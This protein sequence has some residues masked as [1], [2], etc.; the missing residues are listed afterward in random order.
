MGFAR[1]R[2]EHMRFVV[3]IGLGGP[4]DEDNI[5]ISS[6]YFGCE[7]GPLSLEMPIC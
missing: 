2:K 7:N 4:F 3:T 1:L 5:S 6:R